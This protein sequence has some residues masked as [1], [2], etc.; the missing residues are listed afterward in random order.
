MMGWKDPTRKEPV[1]ITRIIGKEVVGKFKG[2]K[3]SE[4]KPKIKPKSKYAPGDAAQLASSS[5]GSASGDAAQLTGTVS[6][7]PFPSFVKRNRKAPI[8]EDLR[9][10]SDGQFGKL[11][12][13][14][15]QDRSTN[16]LIAAENSHDRRKR[17]NREHKNS[18]EHI[19]CDKE[20][21]VMR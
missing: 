2:E 15:E 1:T 6:A 14:V 8:L 21:L 11:Q 10:D 7:N 19:K 3:V 18:Q 16:R 4:A 9:D 12:S 20:S 17:C 13:S 5:A